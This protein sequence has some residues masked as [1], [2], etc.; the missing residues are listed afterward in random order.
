MSKIPLNILNA[1]ELF[2]YDVLY[3]VLTIDGN[4]Y[5]FSNFKFQPNEISVASSG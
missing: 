5:D 4:L 1:G 3:T 2:T